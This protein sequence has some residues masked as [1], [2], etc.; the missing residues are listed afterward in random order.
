MS[1]TF[2]IAGASL[3]GL[4]AAEALRDAGHDGGIVVIGAEEH[5]PYDRP[6][7]SKDVLAGQTEPET[8]A[9]RSPEHY[10]SLGI[11]WELGRRATG[12]DVDD[13]KLALDNGMVF[14][15]DGLVIAT[16]AS[17]R[18]LPGQPEMA[19]IHVLR[20]VDDSVAL[21]GELERR[22]HVVVVGAGF[23]GSE[24]AATA[25]GR[26]CEV[27]V[28]E[29]APVPL[30][31]AL[32]EEMGAAVSA[33]HSDHGVEVRCGVGVEG[34][35]GSGRVETVRLSDGSNVEADVVVVGVG[36]S[37]ETGWLEDSGLALDNGVVCDEACFAADG[38]VAAGDVARWPNPLFGETMRVEH[39]DNAISQGRHAAANLLRADAGE[40][41]EPFA[42]V[43]WFWS[44]QYD[45]KIQFA[46]R[47][48][49]D[50]VVTVVDGSVA[51]ARFAA[52][53]SRGGRV[54]GVLGIDKARP[55][56]LLRPRIAAGVTVEEAEEMFS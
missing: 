2:A 22:P 13:K 1:R 9:L 5:L 4:N 45:S 38:V 42:P 14:P 25:K 35:E 15:F 43:P 34:F 19:G 30:A 37:P 48:S 21:A 56:A 49:P 50:D 54:V 23:I 53:Y 46:G 3:A 40:K 16:G 27:T 20:T 11:D 41:P 10:D 39:W 29:A 26:G 31:H 55:V 6:P 52:V 12:L 36:V 32:G 44:D 33:L 24:V 28:I 51:E 18:R 8:T 17:P 7:L 47:C